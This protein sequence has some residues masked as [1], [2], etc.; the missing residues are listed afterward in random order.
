MPELTFRIE[1]RHAEIAQKW[2]DEHPCKLR[3]SKKTGAI[4]GKTSYSF[5]NT[6][7]G[8]LQ[9]V[10]CACGEDQLVNGDEL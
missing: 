10:Q 2:I 3:K 1:E 8:Q 9:V 7:I 4:G 6:T 5:T